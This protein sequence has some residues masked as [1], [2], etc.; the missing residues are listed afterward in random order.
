M[1]PKNVHTH[2]HEHSH[3]DEDKHDSDLGL[4][5]DSC[6]GDHG[7]ETTSLAW[8]R[9]P[10]NILLAAAALLGTLGFAAKI[11]GA[12]EL[13]YKAIFLAGVLSGGYYPALAA[14]DS[15]KS[16][17]LSINSLLVTAAAGAIY[18]NLWEEAA[19]L[20]VIFSLGGVL[21]TYAVDKAR[22][23]LE[24]LFALTPR[25]AT[26]I[27]GGVET[28]VAVETVASGEFI[29]VKPG[30]RIPLDGTVAAGLST[31]DQS[32]I[33]GESIPVYKKPGDRVFAGTINQNGS[34]EVE[35]T[36]I[37]RET[38]LARVIKSVEEHQAKKSGY[39]RFGDRFGKIYTPTLFAVA[40]GVMA[41]PP[42]LFG[43][44]FGD[45]FYRGLVVL[46]VSCSCGIALSVPVAVV[47]AIAHAARHGILIK[48]GAYLEQMSKTTCVVFD[49]TGTLTYGEPKVT[50]IIAHEGFTQNQ[51]L[52]FAA[53]VE[54][55]SGH[56]LAGAIVNEANARELAELKAQHFRSLPGLGAY[57]MVGKHEYHTGNLRLFAAHSMTLTDA[58]SAAAKTL[59]NQGKSLVFVSEDD[60]L[61]GVI[62]VA[63]TVRES[64]KT[65]VTDL[66]KLGINCITML[67][68]DNNSTAKAIAASIGIDDYR[69]SLLPDH[70][71][72]V[73][74]EMEEKR[75]RT[76]MVGDGINDAPALAAASVGVAMGAAGSGIAVETGDISLMA[77]DLTKLTYAIRLS[78]RTVRLITFNIIAALT[79][80]SVLIVL[81]LTGKVDLV[82]GLFINELGAFLIIL[83]SLRLLV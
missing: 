7:P 32:A 63:D 35:V 28:S 14:F 5:C 64:A 24:G 20:V 9:Q 19:T 72:R 57:A 83:N 69:A 36:S 48:G 37:S 12:P 67:T 41:V 10:R 39:Q 34:L 54:R 43:L 50:D 70:K 23:S 59:E 47:S 82:P 27:R 58:E 81:A 80:V 60:R 78:R 31:V 51:V 13:L 30:D 65:V 75:G 55:K 53:A 66:K 25:E 15:L 74:T 11:A 73:I 52:E 22:G 44:P 29:L 8:Y 3:N 21:E 18:L 56:P 16:A 17:T 6:A 2:D 42:L 61:V 77:D 45:W 71:A 62:A 38:T 68:G 4:K 79:I 76:I 1:A 46:V 33:T 49:K 26:V 40:L